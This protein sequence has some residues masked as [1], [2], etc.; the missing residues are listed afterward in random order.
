MP[1]A[2]VE[3]LR[4]ALEQAEAIARAIGDDPQPEPAGVGY[5]GDAAT[6]GIEQAIETIASYK[7]TITMFVGAGVSMEAE[8]PSWQELVCRLLAA[9][10]SEHEPWLID[11]WADTVLAEGPLAVASVA[12]ALY[13]DDG[14]SFKRAL[15]AALYTRPAAT[16]AP[17]ALADQ[18]A[19]LKQR[20]QK[21]LAL[22]T[23]NY[24]GLLEAA[25]AERGL[26][27]ASF[28]S[29]QQPPNEA[30][31]IRWDAFEP[32]TAHRGRADGRDRTGDLCF[33]RAALCQLSYVGA[34]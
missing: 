17:G 13:P 5:F 8:L 18:I 2:S 33:T 19:W 10:N 3:R 14:L 15:R 34:G 25:L 7:G 32:R 16:Y 28:L 20:L 11:K 22:L 24:D 27:A 31:F 1:S 23:V 30:T 29:P 6:S 26:H 21:R 9:A 4:D 12:E